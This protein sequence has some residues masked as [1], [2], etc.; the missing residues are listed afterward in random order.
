[1]KKVVTVIGARPQFIKAATISRAFKKFP[2]KEVIVHTGQ[3]FDKNMSDIFFSEMQIPLPDYNLDINSLSHGAMTGK[4]LEAIEEILF[5]EKPEVVMVYGDTNS[6]L[7]G[8]LAARKLNIPVVHVEA[9]LRSFN[10][11]M[12]EEIN[13]I[14]TDR[15]SSLLLCP[16]DTAVKNLH[17]ESFD[18]F[19]AI[20]VKN[21]DVM[22]DASLFYSPIAKTKSNIINSL[23]LNEFVLATVH[24]QENTDNIDNLKQII[25]ALN[26]IN[27]S[28][29]VVVPLHPR[30]KNIIQ[31]HNVRPDFTII[32]PVGYF[33]MITLQQN[34]NLILTDSGGVQKE[35]FFFKKPCVTL[36]NETEWTELI[37]HGCNMLA[38]HNTKSII[39]A[40]ETMNNKNIDF[41]ASLYGKGDAADIA[42]EH[43]YNLL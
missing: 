10:N 36:R 11:N 43:I 8:A 14:I 29:E 27:K 7:A 28:V 21:G 31:K 9:G 12:P 32:E 23:N 3:H 19:D 20:I 15:I 6:T 38:G 26:T 35:A 4:M 40:Y 30:T 13:R 22:F 24:R 16:S 2:V 18:K 25:D 39:N 37:E 33:D 1:M 34:C 42:A 5:S 17:N 41:S